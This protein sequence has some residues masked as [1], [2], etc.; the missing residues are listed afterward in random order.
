MSQENLSENKRT[1]IIGE[2]RINHN[3]DVNIAKKIIDACVESG[4]D[5]VK[6]QKRTID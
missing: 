1:Y 4:C 2:I 5:A 6:F 3:G